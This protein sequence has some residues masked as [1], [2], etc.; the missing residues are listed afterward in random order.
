M[1]R[2]QQDTRAVACSDEL[3]AE[4]RTWSRATR[5]P[6][7]WQHAQLTFDDLLQVAGLAADAYD[8]DADLA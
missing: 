8:W 7:A 3:T 5:S 1:D 6:R 4:L 2:R